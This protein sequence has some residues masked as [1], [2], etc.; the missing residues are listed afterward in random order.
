MRRTYHQ[1]RNQISWVSHLLPSHSQVQ[2]DGPNGRIRTPQLSMYH[3]ARISRFSLSTNDVIKKRS[4]PTDRGGQRASHLKRRKPPSKNIYTQ[5]VQNPGVDV[6]CA[7]YRAWDHYGL[8]K[9]TP[10]RSH[11]PRSPESFE[12]AS[13]PR[14]WYQEECA[15]RYK[16]RIQALTLAPHL[17][18]PRG[19]HGGHGAPSQMAAYAASP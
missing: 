4:T 1:R 16:G 5:R 9:H 11:G 3:M 19:G 17:K 14:T 18:T 7:I 2:C 13:A 6:W 10:A 8:R 12:F 15:Q